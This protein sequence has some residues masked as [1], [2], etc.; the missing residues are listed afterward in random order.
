MGITHIYAW[1]N[2]RCKPAQKFVA[3]QGMKKGYN[4]TWFDRKI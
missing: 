3:K 1:V 2:T 4:F